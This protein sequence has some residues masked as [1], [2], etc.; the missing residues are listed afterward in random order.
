MKIFTLGFYLA[1][2]VA[3]FPSASTAQTKIQKIFTDLKHQ[4]IFTDLNKKQQT[5]NN[6]SQQTTNNNP[7]Q[8][9]NTDPQLPDKNTTNNDSYSTPAPNG[10]KAGDVAPD[11]VYIDADYLYPFNGGAAV[12]KKGDAT[13]LIDKTGKFIVPYNKYNF[14]LPPDYEISPAWHSQGG[15][16]LLT[17][18]GAVNSK[19]ELISKELPLPGSSWNYA[20]PDGQ[21]IRATDQK[22]NFIYMDAEGN[23]YIL[24]EGTGVN[25]AEGTVGPVSIDDKDKNRYGYK[26]LKDEWT[27]QPIY[28]WGEPFSDGLACVGKINEFGEMKYGFINKKGKVVIPFIYSNLPGN[29]HGGLAEVLPKENAEFKEAFI[30]KEGNIVQ[31]FNNLISFTYIGNGLNEYT[32]YSE[33]VVDSIGKIQTATEFLKNYG[34]VPDPS[35]H[36]ISISNTNLSNSKFDDNDGKIFFSRFFNNS[37][38]PVNEGYVDIRT[39]K[40]MEGGFS[41]ML[42]FSDGE[43]KLAYGR[44]YTPE[45]YYNKGPLRE[46]YINEDGVFVIVK[47]AASV[48]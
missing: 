18:G 30:D 8:T 29:F 13:A 20:S 24:K 9:T 47:K 22:G 41:P 34:V 37:G 19:G 7:P 21:F 6:N 39:K 26:N 14:R 15:I 48:F 27:V 3:L 16:F 33:Y 43:S 2:I 36:L 45:H 5:T 11:A 38:V 32:Y 17:G 28:D 31:K 10:L 4:K 40:I 42:N 1:I 35:T 12:V 46:G 44:F 25:F 23:K